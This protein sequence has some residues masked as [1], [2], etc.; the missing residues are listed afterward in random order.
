CHP[1]VPYEELKTMDNLIADWEA[2]GAI[3]ETVVGQAVIEDSLA[4]GGYRPVFEADG[5]TPVPVVGIVHLEDGE[6][7]PQV[8][9]FDIKDAEA[10][11]NFLYFYEDK[12]GGIHNPTYAK[13]L[14]NNSLAA[15]Q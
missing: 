10:A 12:S 4:V 13:A 8:G 6:W 9:L 2:L 7:H 3:L 11:W 1:G 15:M 14:I 5:V